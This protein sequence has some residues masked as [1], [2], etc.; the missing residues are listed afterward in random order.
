MPDILGQ[1]TH[2][3]YMLFDL[4][5][6]IVWNRYSTATS[7]AENIFQDRGLVQDNQRQV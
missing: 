4:L 5:I 7:P 1:S 6:D 2:D 3:F